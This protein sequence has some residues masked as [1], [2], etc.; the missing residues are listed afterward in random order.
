M[1]SF[2]YFALFHLCDTGKKYIEFKID[3]LHF[4]KRELKKIMIKMKNRMLDCIHEILY[5]MFY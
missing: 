1:F 2:T 4:Q 3:V 5:G